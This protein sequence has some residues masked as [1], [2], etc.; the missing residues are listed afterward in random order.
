MTLLAA[1]QTLLYRYTGQPDI[2]VGTPISGRQRGETEQLIG[3]FIN[4]IVLRTQLNGNLKLRELLGLVR[5]VG[6]QVLM[7]VRPQYHF[8]HPAQ[9]FA[10]FQVSIQLRTQHYRVDKESD[11]LLSL[12]AL[13]PGNG[14]ADDYVRLSCV[15]I[16]KSLERSQ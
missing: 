10:E 6:L 15:A 11:Q 13:T 16:K 5:E 4:T 3:F 9:Q 2:I 14:R 1:F 12:S 8:P 7:I